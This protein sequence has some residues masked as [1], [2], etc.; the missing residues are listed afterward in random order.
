MTP[1]R[2]H[3]TQTWRMASG[4]VG[5]RKVPLKLNEKFDR[6]TTR[7]ALLYDIECWEIKDE[8]EQKFNMTKRKM[9]R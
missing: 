5:D 9:L 2:K 1:F 7:L 4:V 8:H 3:G 6:T